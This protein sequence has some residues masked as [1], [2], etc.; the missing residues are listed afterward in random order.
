[1]YIACLVAVLFAFFILM[2]AYVSFLKVP[3]NFDCKHAF[4]W[5]TSHVEEMLGIMS[6]DFD[7][8]GHLPIIYSSLVEYLKK[9]M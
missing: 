8:V 3:C 4:K 2:V 6:V 1:M 7:I 9:K 5:L